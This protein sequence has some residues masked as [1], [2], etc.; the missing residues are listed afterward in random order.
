VTDESSI[1]RRGC[2]MLPGRIYICLAGATARQV[3][4][5]TAQAFM[6]PA[7]IWADE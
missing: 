2:E 7:R 4:V 6:L 5:V 3:L 1:V